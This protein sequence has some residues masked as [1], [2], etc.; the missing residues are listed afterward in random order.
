MNRPESTIK[1]SPSLDDDATLSVLDQ[2]EAVD[3]SDE[4]SQIEERFGIAADS[5]DDFV[6][7]RP[8]SKWLALVNRDLQLPQRPAVMGLGMPFLYPD[9]RY[10]RLTTAAAIR[11]GHLAS[12]NVID[13]D[14]IATLRDFIDLQVVTFDPQDHPS[15]TGP[16]HLL[17]RHRG[18]ILGLGNCRRDTPQWTLLAMVPKA[19]REM[20]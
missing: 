1:P 2:V 20:L 3:V 19:W 15:I 14:D 7:F 17:V 16:G 12:R 18:L 11:F 8:N 5:F 13:L 9:M 10:P 4:L 6:V